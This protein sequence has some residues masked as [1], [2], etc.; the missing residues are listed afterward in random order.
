MNAPK[1]LQNMMGSTT[2]AWLQL[3][4]QT[5]TIGLGLP[6]L[7]NKK[8][9]PEAWIVGHLPVY[10]GFTF[11]GGKLSSIN[12]TDLTDEELS[13]FQAIVNKAIDAARPICKQ[14]DEA[15]FEVLEAGG[16][17]DLIPNRVLRG[18][19]PQMFRE[20]NTTLNLEDMTPEDREVVEPYLKKER[21]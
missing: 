7:D 16:E 4:R 12:L 20:I 2:R 17:L 1:R 13:Q 18:S 8:S 11:S 14:L 5:V 19:A 3:A 6:T 21:A 15:A 10:L 9:I